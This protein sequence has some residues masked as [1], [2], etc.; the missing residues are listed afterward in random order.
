MGCFI[1]LISPETGV[2]VCSE[3]IVIEILDK[4]GHGTESCFL[5]ARGMRSRTRNGTRNRNRIMIL[6]KEIYIGECLSMNAERE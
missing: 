1:G 4:T 2:V 5:E 3:H 6:T